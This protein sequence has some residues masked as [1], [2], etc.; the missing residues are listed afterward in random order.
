MEVCVA[1]YPSPINY[2]GE[3]HYHSGS[4]KQEL[5]RTR[6]PSIGGRR[7]ADSEFFQ[8]NCSLLAGKGCIGRDI[9]AVI[10]HRRTFTGLAGGLYGSIRSHL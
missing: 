1:P 2:K 6:C 9:R 3:Y 8:P 4:T 5:E 10:S 7:S